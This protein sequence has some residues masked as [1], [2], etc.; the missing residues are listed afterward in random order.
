MV[1]RTLIKMLSNSKI[2]S[3]FFD[4]LLLHIIMIRMG[5]SRGIIKHWLSLQGPCSQFL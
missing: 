4:K 1:R 5:L 2:L 3:L